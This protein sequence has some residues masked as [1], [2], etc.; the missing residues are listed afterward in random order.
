MQQDENTQHLRRSVRKRKPTGPINIPPS[1]APMA[2]IDAGNPGQVPEP[3][4]EPFVPI[5][6]PTILP[7]DKFSKLTEKDKM[8]QV[9]SVLTKVCDK[10]SDIDNS[11][12][13]ELTGICSRLT[14]CQTQTDNNT[15]KIFQNKNTQDATDKKINEQLD[16]L[17][18][19]N[20][21]L[22]GL[23]QKQHTQISTLNDKVAYLTQKSMENNVVISGLE[24]DIGK[25]EDCVKNVIDFLQGKVQITVA[26]EE[27]MVAH[28]S[29][30]KISDQPRN[31]IVRCTLQLK[32]RILNNSKNLKDLL[33]SKEKPYR[34]NK[35]LPEHLVEKNRQIREKI[36]SIK[37]KEQTL[38]SKERSKIEV[39]GGEIRVNGDS[40][41]TT[42]LLQVQPLELFPDKQEKQ[43][44]DKIKVTAS[45]VIS[46][47]GSDFMSYAVRVT[48]FSEVKRA[49]RKIKALVPSAS[50]VIASYKLRNGYSGYQDDNEYGAGHRMLAIL[51]DTKNISNIAVF[52]CR[53]YGG[54]HLGYR[55]FQIMADTVSQVI[56]R[57]G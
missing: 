43:K 51:Q 36:K 54:H 15:T 53:N 13:D 56:T 41:K 44:W 19:E 5:P 55:R 9:Y 29:A 14:T 4:L 24:G 33:N 7:Q 39:K 37:V 21:I 32:E 48:H 49:Y 10:I 17:K 45:D 28:R 26:E 38:P 22:K 50:H 27:I 3:P 34:I 16:N 23:V 1:L 47:G 6:A 18:D 31:M 11:L 8:G 40:V 2:D 35:Q 20:I 12:Y 46:E 25:S 57:I 30:T 42:H 52:T